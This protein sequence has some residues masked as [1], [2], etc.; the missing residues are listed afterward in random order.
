MKQHPKRQC[1]DPKMG[2]A[3]SRSRKIKDLGVGGK[4][5]SI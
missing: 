3:A 2:S 1:Q 5:E 4:E